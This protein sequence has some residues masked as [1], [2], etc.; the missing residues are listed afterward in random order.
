MKI[1]PKIMLVLKYPYLDIFYYH[2]EHNEVLSVSSPVLKLISHR[3]DF[4]E[5]L[6]ELLFFECDVFDNRHAIQSYS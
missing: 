5:I 2:I 1:L 3:V 6:E 4:I